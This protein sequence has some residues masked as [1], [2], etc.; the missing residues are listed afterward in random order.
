[1][2]DEDLFSHAGPPPSAS[3][4][5]RGDDR[6]PD[7]LSPASPVSQEASAHLPKI[8]RPLPLRYHVR[9]LLVVMVVVVALAGGYRV[10]HAGTPPSPQASSTFQQVHCPFPIGAGLG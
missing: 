3:E 1:M 7:A 6:D 5:E 8:K 4:H 10:F 9:L 2:K